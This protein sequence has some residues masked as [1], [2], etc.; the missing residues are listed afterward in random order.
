M[1]FNMLTISQVWFLKVP[2]F[3]LFISLNSF[4][5]NN[6]ILLC[7]GVPDNKISLPFSVPGIYL[8]NTLHWL[9]GTPNWSEIWLS[10]TW[11]QSEIWLSKTSKFKEISILKKPEYIWRL[12]ANENKKCYL[13]SWLMIPPLINQALRIC[14]EWS[15]EDIF[16]LLLTLVVLPYKK[17]SF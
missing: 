10:G 9:S 7:F 6:Q 2:F 4:V 5:P 3:I 8:F 1:L 15:L 12:F 16:L 17:P 13:S 11:R 14:L